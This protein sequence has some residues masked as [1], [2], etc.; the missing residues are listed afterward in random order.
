MPGS[1]P[2]LP[3]GRRPDPVDRS[4][5]RPLRRLLAAMDDQ[6][7]DVYRH[8]GLAEL[9][10]RFGMPLIRLRHAGPMTIAELA[11]SVAVTHSAM[12]QTVSAMRKAGLIRT[13]T[14]PD[15]RSKRIALTAKASKLVGFLEAEWMA[16]EDA[17]EEIEAEIPY[18]LARAAEEIRKVLESRSF[19]QRIRDHFDPEVAAEYFGDEPTADR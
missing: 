2:L 17:V 9:T 15:A 14:G 6:I 18:A 1:E 19:E 11:R 8:A 12:S 10:P 5:W 7:G 3:A 16:T 13:T 4:T